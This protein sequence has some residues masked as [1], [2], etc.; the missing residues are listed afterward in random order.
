MPD[1]QAFR[2]LMLVE[3]PM[4]GDVMRCVFGIQAH[5]TRTYLTLQDEPE[6]TVEDLTETLERDRS[7]VTR[8]LASLREKGLVSRR[9][10]LL[11]GGGHVYEY[12]ATPLD[13]VKSLMHEELDAWAAF[14][15]D[16]IDSFGPP[17]V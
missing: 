3:N 11:D 9:R 17:R 6:S 12:T 7:N 5:E 10:R 4:F 13:E 8:S 2:E 15:H 14:V 1:R 16:R